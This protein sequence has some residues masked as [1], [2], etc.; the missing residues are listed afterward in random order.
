M[1]IVSL[2]VLFTVWVLCALSHA[3][4]MEPRLPKPIEIWKLPS[5]MFAPADLHFQ[6]RIRGAIE[7][8][9][10][11]FAMLCLMGGDCST[12]PLMHERWSELQIEGEAAPKLWAPVKP[13]QKIPAGDYRFIGGI[14]PADGIRAS[15]SQAVQVQGW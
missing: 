14:G 10:R 15:E 2:G 8:D 3:V 6:I 11:V 1:R 5:V 13:W 9:R 12:E 7:S 4:V